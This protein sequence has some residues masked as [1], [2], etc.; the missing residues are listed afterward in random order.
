MLP[1]ESKAFKRKVDILLRCL[2]CHD[3]VKKDI[4]D[5]KKYCS[6]ECE[7]NHKKKLNKCRTCQQFKKCKV[8]STCK[9][10]FYCSEVCQKKNW[11]EHKKMCKTPIESEIKTEIKFNF[12]KNKW[13][14]IEEMNLNLEY[15]TDQDIDLFFAYAKI[16]DKIIYFK[17][18]SIIIFYRLKGQFEHLVKKMIEKN[19]Y[20]CVQAILKENSKTKCKICSC[21]GIAKK[22][23]IKRIKKD[24]V[25]MW[26]TIP[27]RGSMSHLVK[28]T[29]TLNVM[30][31]DLTHT[32][33]GVNYQ[34]ELRICDIHYNEQPIKQRTF[35]K[36][37]AILDAKQKTGTLIY[38]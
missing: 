13:V 21:N 10:D 12:H 29:N 23:Y 6:D 27:L 20:I 30:I 25:D 4:N 8:C 18:S 32:K 1:C 17:E 22:P 24:D 15:Y 38:S 19:E 33:Q 7:I 28:G 2:C 36:M 16:K 11:D 14:G 35:F 5:P 26:F 3:H 9:I 34:L 37:G 31:G